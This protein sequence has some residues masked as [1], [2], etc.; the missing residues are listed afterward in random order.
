MRY[1]L[2]MQNKLFVK[3][4]IDVF[5][6]AEEQDAF[7]S[8]N[9]PNW[10]SQSPDGSV[11]ISQ[12]HKSLIGNDL[13]HGIE[14]INDTTYSDEAFQVAL[15]YNLT[16]L[17]ISNIHD[18]INWQYRLHAGGHRPVTLV[19]AFEKT[20]ESLKRTLKLGKTVV[21]FNQKLIGKVENLIPLINASLKVETAHHLKSTTIAHVVIENC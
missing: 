19:F 20:K 12:M 1:L 16:I 18:L 17:E 14:V 10:R 8:W 3:D 13:L 6:A 9:H 2:R 21:W 15:D 4:P 7:V 5:I 11:L